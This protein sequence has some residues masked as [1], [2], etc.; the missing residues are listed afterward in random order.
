MTT[1]S[2]RDE[3]WRGVGRLALLVVLGVAAVGV[4]R[5]M[6]QAPR[7]LAVE[8]RAVKVRVIAAP[9]VTVQASATGYGTVAPGRTWEAVAEVSG[10]IA[11]RSQAL[12]DGNLVKAGTELLRI[13]DSSYRLALAQIEAELAASAAKDG[14]NRTSLRIK[15]RDHAL[16]EAEL[17]RQTTLAAEGTVSRSALELVQRQLLNSETDLQ[18]LKG[19]VAVGKAEREVLMARKASAELELARTVFK[20]PIDVRIVDVEVDNGQYVSKGQPLFTGD[21]LAVAEVEGQFPIGRL[22]PLVGGSQARGDR[23]AG[24]IDWVPGVLGLGAV[25]R[26]RS[27]DHATQWKARVDRVVGHVDA[28]TQSLGIVVAIDDPYGKA[29]PGSR[30]PLVRNMFVEV[31]IRGN[32]VREQV[33]IPRSALHEGNVYVADDADRLDIRPVVIGFSEGGFASVA[34]GVSPGERVVVSDP[35]PA[36]R[37]MLLEPIE[38]EAAGKRLVAAASGKRG[39]R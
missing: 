36:V 12:K 19:A 24:A 31:E 14:M 21:G 25:V 20:A 18:N 2:G 34:Q 9:E 32:P 38:D 22:R 37:G 26:L 15:E 11:W 4:A 27:A 39:S 7:R 16:L 17:K 29:Q 5:L 1:N 23:R 13:D 10:Q 35:V 6:K 33:V 30:P 3:K 28:A 8:E